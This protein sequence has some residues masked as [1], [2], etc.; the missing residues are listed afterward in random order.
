MVSGFSRTIG[1]VMIPSRQGGDILS[2]MWSLICGWGR[3]PKTLVWDREAAIG[4][5]G[6]VSTAASAFAGAGA[7]T[8]MSMTG[9]AINP[10]TA[11][12]PKCSIPST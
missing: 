8:R 10:G 12:L 7:P 4:G 6:R 3:V 11:V 2:G 9:L 1:A 5:T